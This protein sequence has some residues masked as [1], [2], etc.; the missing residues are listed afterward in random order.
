MVR[1]VWQGGGYERWLCPE[2]SRGVI[3]SLTFH[4]TDRL[5]VIA[6]SREM[7][8]WDWEKAEPFARSKT[9]STHERFR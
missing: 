2:G 6:T 7:F 9:E 8:F 5:L 3:V 1:N 4:P